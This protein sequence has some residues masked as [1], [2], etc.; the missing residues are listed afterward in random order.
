M[1]RGSNGEE[2][3]EKEEGGESLEQLRFVF[4]LCDTDRDGVISVEEFRRIGLDHF[5][6]TK[7]SI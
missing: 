5:D 7:V 4:N 6:R 1:E 2:E 3:G